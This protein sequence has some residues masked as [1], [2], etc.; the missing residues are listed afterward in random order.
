MRGLPALLLPLALT[1]C[2]D[3]N[4]DLS[5]ID[6]T[7]ELKVNDL[8]V[9][10][11]FKEIYLDKVIDLDDSD[12]DAVIK[13]REVNG[14]RCYVLSKGGDFSADPK[15]IDKIEAPKPDY[16][17]STSTRV[18]ANGADLSAR[19]RSAAD[20]KEYTVTYHYNDYTYRVGQDGNPSVDDAIVS[21]DAIGMDPTGLLKVGLSINSDEIGRKATHVELYD[22]V[23]EMPAGVTARYGNTVSTSGRLTIPHLTSDN[24]RMNVQLEVTDIDFTDGAYPDGIPVHDGSFDYSGRLAIAS[25]RFLVY[26]ADGYSLADLPDEID[27]TTRY[28][29]SPFTVAE[30]TGVFDY[31]VDFDD[32]DPIDL[33]DLPEFLAGEQTDLVMTDPSL[34]LQVN[35]PVARYGLNCTTG[36]TLTAERDGGLASRTESVD[37]FTVGNQAENQFIALAPGQ[38]ALEW[39]SV[40]AGVQPQFTPFPGLGNLLSGTG[41]PKRINVSFKSGS[42]PAPR[43]WGKATRFRLGEDLAQVHGSYTF[44][45][46][47]APA[48]GSR[49]VYSHTN[50]GWN[51]EDV[52]AIA[53]SKMKVTASLS[54]TIPAA[55]KIWL[56]PVDKDGNRIPLT[57]AET[58]YA[59][60]SAMAV[61]EPVSL[62]LLGDI[63]HLDGIYIEAVVDG[64]DGQV[65]SPD[66]TI[67]VADLRVTV[68]GTYT[69]EL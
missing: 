2:V 26:P 67:K 12:P 21:V 29:I 3:D 40:P 65:L 32:I 1:G 66:Q 52:D 63:R 46:P 5:D 58:A 35:S 33:S 15:S 6:T 34:T 55:A 13:V 8:T 27:F 31:D 64:F 38:S 9:P 49:V 30:F 10:I 61:N 19:R 14:Q 36:L 39:V 47:L 37:A 28:D 18:F 54:S 53:I 59:T 20:Y 41:L 56:R 45:A 23:L 60:L 57:N 24:G 16:K 22:L 25:G 48:T 4:Y 68:T 43:V 7:T 44:T 42:S 62:E 50:D 11:N 51:D 17:E 69:K